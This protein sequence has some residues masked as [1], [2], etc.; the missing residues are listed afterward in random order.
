MEAVLF[1]L[2]FWFPK[3]PATILR[4][5]SVLSHVIPYSNFGEVNIV[6]LSSLSCETSE[7][8]RLINCLGKSQDSVQ[9]L[10]SS[11]LYGFSL[12]VVDLPLCSYVLEWIS[13][14]F[15]FFFFFF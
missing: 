3:L 6:L 10:C 12:D 5:L 11:R 13:N 1:V 9:I 14:R 8:Q 15:F 2:I 7:A 4:T